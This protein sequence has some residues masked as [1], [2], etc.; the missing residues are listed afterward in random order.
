MNVFG[1]S[2]LGLIRKNNEDCYLIDNQ[3]FFEKSYKGLNKNHTSFA[4]FDGLGGRNAGEVASFEAAKLL[5][6]KLKETD[7]NFPEIIIEINE[8]IIKLGN[9]K[10]EYNGMGTTIAGIKIED[11]TV[12]VYN[13]GDSIIFR[14]RDN[15]IEELTV[16]HSLALKMLAEGINL[17]EANNFRH[18]MTKCLGKLDMTISDVSYKR[19]VNGAKEKDL[20]LLTTDGVTDLVTQT[21]ILEIFVNN[22]IETAISKLEH[23]ILEKG[24]RD[25][26]TLIV[27]EI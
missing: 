11:E 8:E 18:V 19:L 9:S 12:H 13:M 17:E 24:A 1:M 15:N 22:N 27:V 4:V 16:E 5:A 20:F 2:K 10:T 14:I 7:N 21:E 23:N 25:N 26:Y 6:K 3:V